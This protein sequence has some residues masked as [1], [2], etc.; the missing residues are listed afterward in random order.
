MVL[1]SS[2]S[3]FLFPF[4]Q[5]KELT[6]I[7]QDLGR[8]KQMIKGPLPILKTEK[9]GDHRGFFFTEFVFL[10]IEKPTEEVQCLSV[11]GNV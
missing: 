7:F 3:F 4:W 5:I 6:Q 11:A 9:S 1:I 10:Q 2:S 8:E